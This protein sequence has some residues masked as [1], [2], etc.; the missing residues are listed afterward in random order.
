MFKKQID[1]AVDTIEN[2]HLVEKT[3]LTSLATTAVIVDTD[4]LLA[5]CEN[6]CNKYE[7]EKPTIRIL[8]HL[9]C[10]GGS[11]ISKCIAS[12]ANVFLLSEVHPYSYSQLPDDKPRFL[13]SDLAT[14]A[15][16]AGFPESK[17]LAIKIF[18]SS[19]EQ[20]HKH[21]HSRGAKLI[22]RDHSHSDFCVGDKG[23]SDSVIIKLLE[24]DYNILNIVTLRNPIDSY[25]SLK[26][27]GW[28]RFNP[29]T[30]D[31][32]CHRVLLFLAQFQSSDIYFY[33]D[34]ISAPHKN[35]K[36]YCDCLEIDFD[37]S[38][39][40]LFDAQKVTGDSGRKG[41]IIAPRERRKLDEALIKEINESKN[42][43]LLCN[44]YELDCLI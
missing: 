29:S 18:K 44:T 27:F 14:L 32:Y 5:R 6:I 35:L 31:E 3:S 11:L 33:E 25:A 24:D 28:I 13:P 4:S 15:T 8:H 9:A 40:Y 42:F 12:M 16:H 20:V 39:E 7:S 34:F 30:F 10:S 36:K 26:S 23:E 38:Y 37:D 19:I 17:D 1:D 22:L 43:E 41:E 21:V 2:A